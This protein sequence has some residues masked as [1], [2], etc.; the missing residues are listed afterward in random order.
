MARSIVSVDRIRQLKTQISSYSN[1]SDASISTFRQ[2][3]S[4]LME[5]FETKLDELEKIMDE[6]EQAYNDC[7]W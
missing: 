6:K 7:E 1:Q 5:E 3:V 4:F 2:Q